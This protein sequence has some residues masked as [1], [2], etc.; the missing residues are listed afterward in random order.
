MEEAFNFEQSLELLT[1]IVKKME[2]NQMSL[3]D[4]LKQYEEGIRLARLCE[5]HLKDAEA[6]VQILTQKAAP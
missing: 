2:E 6:R 5:V 3:E 4:A 1:K